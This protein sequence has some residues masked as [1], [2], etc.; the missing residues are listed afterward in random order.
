M[1]EPMYSF[2]NTFNI[3]PP[4]TS[5]AEYVSFIEQHCKQDDVLFRGQDIDARLLP[6]LARL[7]CKTEFVKS[8]ASMLRQ[9]KRQSS[10]TLRDR[11][12]REWDWLALAQHHGLATRLLDWS[13]NPLT[14]LWFAV[15]NPVNKI[16]PGVVWV[17]TPTEDD[18][19]QEDCTN[20]LQ[21]QQTLILVPNCIS[22][23]ITSQSACFTIH[24][25]CK[26]APFLTAVEDEPNFVNKL[27]KI[28]IP[29]EVFS[30]LRYQLDRFGVNAASLFPGIDGLCKHIEWLHTYTEDEFPDD[31]ELVTIGESS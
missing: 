11:P 2:I 26:E 12:I 24:P 1:V 4:I 28:M 22:E 21:L 23:R 8:E 10:P 29:R 9:L 27:Q 20:P 31:S 3:S 15:G 13:L 14:A 5:L 30:D 16:G 6:R 7:N 25:T 19:A 17:L 18:Y